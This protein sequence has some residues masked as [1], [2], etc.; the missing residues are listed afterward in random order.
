MN[1]L[2]VKKQLMLL[3]IFTFLLQSPSHAVLQRIASQGSLV[4]A[5]TGKE[6]TLWEKIKAG[7]FVYTELDAIQEIKED[8]ERLIKRTSDIIKRNIDTIEKVYKAQQETEKETGKKTVP[9]VFWNNQLNKI[10]L[11]I[12]NLQRE[13]L[14]KLN[15]TDLK[16][17][18]DPATRSDFLDL[19]SKMNDSFDRTL[20]IIPEGIQRELFTRARRSLNELKRNNDP[21][22]DDDDELLHLLDH[23]LEPTNSDAE[24]DFADVEPATRPS[25]PLTATVKKQNSFSK[26]GA[27]A[28]TS[29]PL[30]KKPSNLKPQKKPI[31]IDADDI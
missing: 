12:S 9:S 8:T 25:T 26:A 30:V 7:L 10:K 29:T 15:T 2:S 13:A 14:A 17:F 28:Q 20:D 18:V 24:Y 22:V 19:I 4:K 16:D 31:I 3:L 27:R 23:N 11:E 21:K 1:L 6:T 5:I